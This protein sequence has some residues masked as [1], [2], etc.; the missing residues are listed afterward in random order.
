M[1]KHEVTISAV[2]WMDENRESFT[3]IEDHEQLVIKLLDG[4]QVLAETT[5]RG[6]VEKFLVISS[7]YAKLVALFNKT[8]QGAT[9]Q[10]GK[11]VIPGQN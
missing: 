7:E 11:I 4:D 5:L 1:D 2:Y 9:E 3:D 8:A 6:L 10:A